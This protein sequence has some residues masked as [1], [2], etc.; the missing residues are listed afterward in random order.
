MWI[1]QLLASLRR[2]E[3]HSSALTIL[4]KIATTFPQALHYPLRAFIAETELLLFQSQQHKARSEAANAANGMPLHFII[5]IQHF[6]DIID[7]GDVTMS[8]DVNHNENCMES[9]QMC[10]NRARE[11][12]HQLHTSHPLLI[13]TIELMMK[14][15]TTLYF[16]LYLLFI[17][18]F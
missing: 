16:S 3:F 4:Q 17:V 9:L 12:L 15:V 1:P 6:N 14:Y 11:L 18:S 10:L 7:V 13:A 2:I 5:K 8:L